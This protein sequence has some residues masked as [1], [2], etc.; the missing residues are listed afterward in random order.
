MAECDLLAALARKA[1]DGPEKPSGPLP[2]T[3]PPRLRWRWFERK[4]RRN[5]RSCGQSET[6]HLFSL[7]T[8]QPPD[9]RKLNALSLLERLQAGRSDLLLMH[10]DVSASVAENDSVALYVAKPFHAALFHRRRPCTDLP[11]EG[12]RETE[13]G[14]SETARLESGQASPDTLSIHAT[15]PLRWSHLPGNGAPALP[16]D[17]LRVPLRR[18]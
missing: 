16:V 7:Q 8:L 13:N 12:R 3:S 11:A 5:H 4:T 1:Q 10:E 2:P 15:A 6:V 17:L 14:S 9:G 18:S